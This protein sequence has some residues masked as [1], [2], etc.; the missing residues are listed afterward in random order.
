MALPG[1][2]AGQAVSFSDSSVT[3]RGHSIPSAGI[4]V[5]QTPFG[6]R[7]V[8]L[9]HEV[10]DLG[11]VDE[12]LEPVGHA[13]R[14]EQPEPVGGGELHPDVVAERGRAGPQ[15]DPDVVEATAQ[16]NGRTCPPRR[17]QLVVQAPHRAGGCGEAGVGLHERGR[18]AGGGELVG[19]ER[20]GEPSSLVA[21]ALELDDD[22]PGDRPSGGRS[23]GAGA[24]EAVADGVPEEL[25][26]DLAGGDQVV[27]GLQAGEA[28]PL[29]AGRRPWRCARRWRGAGGPRARRRGWHGTRGACR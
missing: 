9:G 17:R 24:V 2:N 26:V 4:V 6:L 7:G 13:L 18:Q 16:R 12:G 10:A 8:A 20:A 5:A 27:D 25:V 3:G 29:E 1:P 11:G 15:V 19:A 22:H 28:P 21:V 23:S 14:E